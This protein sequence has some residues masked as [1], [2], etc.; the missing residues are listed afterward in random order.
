M[1]SLTSDDKVP[2]DFEEAA[3]HII[4]TKLS[5]ARSEI[6]TLETDLRD[7]KKQLDEAK[8]NLEQAL[9]TKVRAFRSAN[10]RA[11]SSKAPSYFK[12]S[13]SLY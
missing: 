4:K 11:R 12:R 9:E 5:H 2:R 7:T 10:E 1:F 8:G 6:R 3:V 13:V